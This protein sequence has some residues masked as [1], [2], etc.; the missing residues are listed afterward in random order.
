MGSEWHIFDDFIPD[1]V[2]NVPVVDINGDWFQN[3]LNQY[4]FQHCLLS[5]F[6]YND[7]RVFRH[8]VPNES[9]YVCEFLIPIK[10]GK[11]LIIPRLPLLNDENRIKTILTLN[12]DG[13]PQLKISVDLQ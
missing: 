10:E 5:L 7:S 12:D 11:F 6:M 8:A 1:K 9:K 4:L 13:Q 2:Y 3:K